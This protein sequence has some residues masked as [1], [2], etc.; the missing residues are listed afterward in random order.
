MTQLTSKLF[1]PT[2]GSRMAQAFP[3]LSAGDMTSIARFGGSQSF[4]DGDVLFRA[5]KKPEGMY[6]IISGSVLCSQRDGLGHVTPI[7]S[8]GLGHFIA[9]VGQLSGQP[10]FVDVV[11]TSPVRAW[12]VPPD[13]LRTALISD[14]DLGERI[15]R[16]LMLRR[17]SLIEAG[18]GNAL[19]IGR[20]GSMDVLRLQSFLTRNSQPNKLLDPE[21]DHDAAAFV[22]QLGLTCEELP[23][24]ICP[25]GSVLRNPSITILAAALGMS[26]ADRG[27]ETFDLAVVGAGPAGLSA[28]VYAS[29][30]GLSVA[31]LDGRAHGGQAGAS[32]RIENYL[33]FPTGISGQ[34]LVSRALVQAQKFGAKMIIPATITGMSRPTA[35]GPFLLN[36]EDGWVVRARCVVVAT[37][38]SYRRPEIPHLRDFEGRGIRYWASAL[39]AQMCAG[40]EVIVVGGGNSAGQASVFLSNYASKVRMMIRGAGLRSTMSSY[41]VE[42]IAASD[43]IE[44]MPYTEVTGLVSGPFGNLDR[45]DWTGVLTGRIGNDDIRHVF[46]F[47]GADPATD[48][49]EG[50]GLA[51]D[52]AQFVVTGTNAGHALE[53]SIEG[54]FAAG[55]ARSGSVKR[56]G[57]AIGEGAQ[58][59]AAVHSYLAASKK[60]AEEPV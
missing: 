34:A 23:V 50:C 29:S 54:V 3:T 51:L 18:A 49:L 21:Q 47:A 1:S 24:A 28:A 16:A 11:A 52:R 25:D 22:E 60:R 45:V 39:E 2:L 48:W 37:G 41:L 31:V 33:G 26:G 10:A 19:L 12:L 55:D 4:E 5:E 30:E 43:K 40:S 6:V 42:R 56:V 14:A 58:V 57:A 59:V 27:D 8:Q 17:I 36:V 20:K 15:M 53:T 7:V 9:E 46:I 38:A 35:A 44:V 13:R 32:A